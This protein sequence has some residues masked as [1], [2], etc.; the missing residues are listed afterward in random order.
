MLVCIERRQ[1]CIV[2]LSNDVRSE[3]AFP[4]RVAFALGETGAPWRWEYAD[5]RFWSD[6]A[7]SRSTP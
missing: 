1:R 5:M 3:A 4:R 2:L 7:T 6:A